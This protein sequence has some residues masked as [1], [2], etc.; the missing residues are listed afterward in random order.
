M[1]ENRWVSDQHW[2]REGQQTRSERTQTALIDATEALILEKGT[3]ATSIADIA[4]RAGCSVGTVYHHFKD[5]KALFLALFERM[6]TRYRALNASGADPARWEGAGITDL[7]RG[8][9][10]MTL[11]AYHQNAAAKAAVS[12][13]MAD[14]PELAS[15]YAEI[16]AET[17]RALLALMMTRRAEIGHP[18]PEDAVPF[19]I[20]ALAALLRARMDPSQ[21]AAAL[22][23]GTDAEFIEQALAMAGRYLHLR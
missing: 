9:L 5:K 6:T 14:F 8:Y 1:S 12:A 21:R 3:E 7:M 18:A 19:V 13:V 17:R 11:D 20:D 16:Q 22:Q 15:H 4:A 10:T 2:R 23:T